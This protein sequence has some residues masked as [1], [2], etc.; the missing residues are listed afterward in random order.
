[1]EEESYMR[2]GIWGC[3]SAQFRTAHTYISGPNSKRGYGGCSRTAPM[4]VKTKV[5]D[6][7]AR[8]KIRPSSSSWMKLKI[9]ELGRSMLVKREAAD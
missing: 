7:K 4:I 3:S 6:R 5:R 8:E 1:M 2:L 9:S